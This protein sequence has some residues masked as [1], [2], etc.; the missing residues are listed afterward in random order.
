MSNLVQQLQERRRRETKLQSGLVVAWHYPDVQEC[1]L[2]VGAIPLPVL[3]M[4]QDTPTEEEAQR[5]I[6][7]QPEAMAR[8]RDFT[9]HMVAAMLD[10]I[11]GQP[12]DPDDDRLG[13]VDLLEPAERQELF[14]IATRQKD[15]DS[16]EA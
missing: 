11:D 7:E 16:G 15:P 9:R 2:K 10:E 1:I 8:T 6:V 5:L 13:I 12:V 3:A 4:G 14:L